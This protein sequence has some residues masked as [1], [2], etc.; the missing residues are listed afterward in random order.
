MTHLARFSLFD[1]DKRDFYSTGVT[2]E[3]ISERVE[4]RK[5]D[6]RFLAKNKSLI[7]QEFQHLLVTLQKQHNTREEFWNYLYYCCLMLEAYYQAYDNKLKTEEYSKSAE[8]IRQ[9]MATGRMPTA[10]EKPCWF[11]TSL[12]RQVVAEFSELFDTPQHLSKIRNKIGVL[13][14]Y[15][16]YWAFCR[17]MLT[18]ALLMNNSTGWIDRLGKLLHKKIDVDK[19]IKV[20]EK[21]NEVFRALSVGFFAARFMLNALM[22]LKHTFFP[23]AEEQQLTRM[24]RFSGEMKKRYPDFLNDVVWGTVNGV[25]NYAPYLHIA[26]PIAG[27]LTGG[28]LFFDVLL[29]LWRR[30]L[31]EK[32]YSTKKAQYLADLAHYEAMIAAAADKNECG[33]AIQQCQIIRK[34]LSELD[35]TWQATSARFLF[36]AGAALLL[37]SGFSASM[38]FA[39]GVM[40]VLAYAACVFAVAMYLSDAE[41]H[42]YKESKLRLRHAELNNEDVTAAMKAYRTARYE[43]ATTLAKNAIIP[44]LIIAAYAIC[45]QAALVL[46]VAFIAYELTMAYMRHRAKQEAIRQAAGEIEQSANVLPLDTDLNSDSD[47]DSQEEENDH[48]LPSS[49]S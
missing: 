14:I 19:I 22:V 34:Q 28:F 47:A 13:N 10:V 30:H 46:T 31:A 15:R 42:K 18:A 11:I 49:S 35:I 3:H 45:W 29:L 12:G 26:A 8:K 20:L 44:G 32:D 36:N 7:E 17:T 40:V 2:L 37:A 41:Y 48:L 6:F 9:Y 24:E 25:S 21:P 38:L 16:I 5:K 43:F 39:P 23:E 4:T 27:W 1:N 33:L